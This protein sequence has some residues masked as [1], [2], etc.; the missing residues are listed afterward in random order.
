MKITRKHITTA[1]VLMI[2]MFASGAQTATM[3]LDNTDFMRSR[4]TRIF[5]FEIIEGGHFKATLTDFEFL[6]PFDVPALAILKGKEIVGGHLLGS[7]ILKF[8]A[9]PSIFA[10]N[11]F[12]IAWGNLVFSLSRLK[13]SDTPIPAA[14]LLILAGLIGLIALKRRR[15]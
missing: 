5:P 2:L 14:A 8:Q 10:A 12:R 3:V 1:G 13:M 4:E 11:V 9:E 6:A 7:E 15:K